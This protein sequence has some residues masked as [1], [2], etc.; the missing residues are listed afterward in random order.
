M[1]I[2]ASS[3]FEENHKLK[4]FLLNFHRPFLNS[5]YLWHV[6]LFGDSDFPGS[7]NWYTTGDFFNDLSFSSI[8]QE[9]D[10]F[11]LYGE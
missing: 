11:K 2:S 3:I 4:T 1:K 10:F 9:E 6:I 5:F 7:I 8:Y